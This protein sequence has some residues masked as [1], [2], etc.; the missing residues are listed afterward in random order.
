VKFKT[1]NLGNC[2]KI[3]PSISEFVKNLF[4]DWIPEK[5]VLSRTG[6]LK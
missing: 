3:R 4:P 6:R 2:Q 1:L 5:S